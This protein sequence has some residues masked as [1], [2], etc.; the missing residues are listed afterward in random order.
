VLNRRIDQTQSALMCSIV[1]Y[2]LGAGRARC[3]E[4]DSS[5]AY[6]F[7]NFSKDWPATSAM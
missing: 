3:F 2:E 4:S 5:A 7:T 6:F 1:T